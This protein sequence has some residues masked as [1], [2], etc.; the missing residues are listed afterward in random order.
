MRVSVSG[1]P[2]DLK[3]DCAKI[4]ALFYQQG[5]RIIR[6]DVADGG[7][8]AR[9]IARFKSG[10][11]GSAY[12]KRITWDKS[13]SSFVGFGGGSIS[14]EYGPHAGG[15][16]VGGG[17]RHGPPNTDLENSLDL[18]RPKF[19]RDVDSMLHSLFWPGA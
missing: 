11:H 17:W 19:H 6:E 15:T 1:I 13:A 16:P 18:I 10:P 5:R 9:R 14:G 3:S 12:Y 4:P 2:D 8:T 7:K